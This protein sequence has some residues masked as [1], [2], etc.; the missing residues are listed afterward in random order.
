MY[1]EEEYIHISLTEYGTLSDVTRCYAETERTAEE[2]MADPTLDRIR[3]VRHEISAEFGH[4]PHRLVEHYLAIQVRRSMAAS[5]VV[6]VD[7]EIV[8]GMPVF[9]GTR[10]PVKH[11]FDYLQGGHALDEFLDDF[12]SVTR[13]QAVSALDEAFNAL[14]ASLARS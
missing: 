1:F 14:G 10:V 11:L 2:R 6:C 4:D 8:G 3:R 13:E 5:T 7:P 12:P 9:S